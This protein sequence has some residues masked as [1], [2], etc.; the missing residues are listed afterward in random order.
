MDD[1]RGTSRQ[2][3][4]KAG[5]IEMVSGGAL[6]CTVRNLSQVGAALDVTSPVGIPDE[7]V[8][9]IASD[10]LRFRCRVA[11]RKAARIGVR[12]E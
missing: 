8:L 6:E 2:R 10:A 11:W 12:F 3:I 7:F 5:K 4:L 1:R 9:T